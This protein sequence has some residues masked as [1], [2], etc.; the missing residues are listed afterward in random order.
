MKP[1]KI[2]YFVRHGQSVDNAAPVFQ[3]PN[4]SL[5]KNGR[6]QAMQIAKRVST[7]E[8]DV[9]ISSPFQRAKETTEVISK[10]TGRQ[11]EFSPLFTERIKPSSIDGKSYTDKAASDLWR[12]W[13]KSLFTPGMKVEDGENYEEIVKRADKALTFLSN[14][15]EH[16]IVVVT[17]GY[18]L[19]TIVSRILLGELL[20][21]TLHKN[22]QRLAWMEN[23]GLTVIRYQDAFEEDPCWRLWIYNDHTHLA[24]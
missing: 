1:Q 19:R 2:V 11:A 23:T 22:F 10:V 12:K 7:L 20:S 24:E 4:S 8:F 18:F 16:S 15:P 17:H 3:A 21:E 13:E 6:K 5:S 9:L 14:R